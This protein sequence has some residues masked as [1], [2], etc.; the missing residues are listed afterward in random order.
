MRNV[1]T[2]L[3]AIPLAAII[4]GCDSNT[5]IARTQEKQTAKIKQMIVLIKKQSRDIAILR[6]QVEANT[7]IKAKL[8]ISSR[9]KILQAALLLAEQG[10]SNI[11]HQAMYILGYLG[12]EKAENALLKMLADGSRGRNSSA[13]INALVTMRSRK[14]RPV[15]IKLLNS[16]NHQDIAAATN[17]LNNR[18]LRILKK[19]D[20]PL[21]IKLLDDMSYD[22][23]NR[24]RRNN[25]LRAICQLDQNT[26][27]KYICEALETADVNQQRELCYIPAH[28]GINL[29]AKSWLKIIKIL[30][31]PNGQNI[32]TFQGV[33]TGIARSGDMRLMDIA[34][35]WAELA[36]DNSSFRNTYIDMLNRMRDPKT[37]KIFLD[38]CL[39][40]GATNNHYMNCL[41]NFPGIIQKDGKY[42]L[43]DDAAMKKLLENRAKLI[44]RLNERDKRKAAKK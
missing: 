16:S 14:L 3:I 23:N 7:A 25:I 11:S 20:L 8:A 32:S 44:T 5:E 17:A 38:L 12:G 24:Y 1:L 4:Y 36:V 2:V 28:G 27:I 9:D 35:S 10:P 37:A 41:R 18:S 40:N 34:L 6:K 39:K 26:G 15:I 29:S 43:V 42:Q 13:I 30:G 22:V 33:C 31:E 19:S 21:L